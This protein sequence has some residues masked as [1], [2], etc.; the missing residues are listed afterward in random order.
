MILIDNNQIMIANVF[1]TMRQNR[2]IDEDFLRHMVLNTY[3]MFRTKFKKEYGELVICND[4][5][6]YWRKEI[7]PQYK[8]SRKKNMDK[9]D[10]DWSYIFNTMD[11]IKREI[12]DTFPYKNLRVDRTEADD[13]IGVLCETYHEQEKILIVS[14]DKDF[15]QLQR[16][17]NVQQYS[18][19]KKK[20]LVCDN[21][22]EFLLEHIIKGDS[23][24]G[25]PNI[26]SDDDVFVQEDKRQNPC[27]KKKITSIK[28]NLN[29][30][31]EKDNWKR[32]QK[33]I[34]MRKIPDIFKEEILS[35]FNSEVNG[36]RS[37]LL[38][39]FIN[40][41]LRNLMVNIGDF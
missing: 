16:Y 41:N 15:Q 12:K 38:N 29:E 2:E 13:I 40:K 33:L 34:D 26:L 8:A 25:I 23:S 14:N 30:W 19:S 4:S 10:V 20:L 27:G 17:K 1:A 32:N 36:K 9:S 39:Y 37:N 24:D 35:Q 6:N 22:E 21:P 5:T 28:E 31:T 18:P 3:R 7:F 11:V